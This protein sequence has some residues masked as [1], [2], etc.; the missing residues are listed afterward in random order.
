[1]NWISV[2]DEL[3]P[4]P[5]KGCGSHRYICAYTLFTENV[6]VGELK[7]TYYG[8]WV[9]GGCDL[10]NSVTHWMPLPEPPK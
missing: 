10:H 1:M 4:L 2:K 8:S 3:P 5:S 7:Y 6:L 9:I